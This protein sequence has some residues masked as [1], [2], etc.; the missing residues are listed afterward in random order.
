MNN[1]NHSNIKMIK[2]SHFSTKYYSSVE[3]RFTASGWLIQVRTIINI[4]T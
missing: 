3:R 1:N 2:L 4:L